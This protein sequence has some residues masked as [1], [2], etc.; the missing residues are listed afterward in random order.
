MKSL[1]SNESSLPQNSLP[2][3]YSSSPQGFVKLNFDGASK[4]NPRL[5]SYGGLI[6]DQ[7]HNVLWIYV[8]N[9]GIANNNNE[10]KFIYL[11]RGL[12]LAI[13]AGY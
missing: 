3:S 1:A 6:R 11:E 7:E 8:E 4:G 2:T 10:A 5:A 9:Y 12:K 13:L